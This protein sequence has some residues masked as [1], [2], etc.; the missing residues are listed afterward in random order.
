MP[1]Q[2][3][4]GLEKPETRPMTFDGVSLKYNEV[5]TLLEVDWTRH[6]T[7]GAVIGFADGHVKFIRQRSAE[8]PNGLK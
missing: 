4:M 7:P 6:P 8:H 1:R 5:G 3:I 2:N